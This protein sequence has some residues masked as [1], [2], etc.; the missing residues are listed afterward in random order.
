MGELG[1]EGGGWGERGEEGSYLER[2]W[3]RGRGNGGRDAEGAIA[4]AGEGR[5]LGQVG[6]GKEGAS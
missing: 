2:P 3:E 6:E 5:K 4:R 1:G